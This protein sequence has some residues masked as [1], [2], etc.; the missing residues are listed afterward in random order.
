MFRKTATIG[1]YTRPKRR[2]LKITLL[3]ILIAVLGFGFWIGFSAWRSISK[4]T[5]DSDAGSG[6]FFSF[7][8]DLS[9]RSIKG[10]SEGRTN[11]LLL[12][13]GGRNHPGGLL[14]DTIIILSINWQ[15]KKMAMVSV[16]RDLWVQVPNYGYTK[17]NG[18]YAYGEQN[19]KT[20]GGGGKVS[21]E[22]ISTVL[23]IPI[24]YYA[25]LDFDGFEKMIDKVGGVDI[26]V[27]KDL[28]DPYFP[29]D[30]MVDYAPLTIKTGLQHMNGELALKY[31]RS[32]KT[33][34]DFDRSKRQEQ[35]IV[36]VKDKII[37]MDTLSN[38]KKITDLLNILGDHVRTNFSVGEIRS[39]WDEIKGID[40]EHIINK[41]FDTAANG[42]LTSIS[43]ERGYIIVPKKGVNNFS[44][45]Q[46]IVKNIFSESEESDKELAIEV[47]NGTSKAGLAN[48]ISQLL[49]SYG[50]N[51]VAVGNAS[52]SYTETTVY[53]CDGQEAATAAQELAN[54]LKATV[55]NKTTCQDID[56][57]IIMGQ[58]SL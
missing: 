34:S 55:K 45:L 44:D 56:V 25:S 32:R 37:S 17:I 30:N 28:Y 43:D 35:V 41:V 15:N 16:P 31:A 51:V 49:Q 47:L 12:G 27:E 40:T 10:Q 2:A 9:K 3:V 33:T 58:S 4:I 54:T 26:Y 11:I 23:G 6:N 5:A 8:D 21:S 53:N 13:N 1:S 29:A 24:H 39:L 46:I 36:A 7:F 22:V 50:Y 52:S 48:Q 19:S 57:Q 18:A 14:S 38:P 20:T 42:P